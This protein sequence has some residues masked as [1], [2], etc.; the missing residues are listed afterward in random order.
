[1][2]FDPVIRKRILIGI[3]V[4]AGMLL[5]V[6][7]FILNSY[8]SL[9]KIGSEA[10]N[11]D[12]S[13]VT[14]DGTDK[15]AFNL[16]GIFMVPRSSSTIV[17]SGD[18]T[19][20]RAYVP[21]KAIIGITNVRVEISPQK[22]VSKIG[23]EGL[24]CNGVTATNA[25]FTYDCFG[26]SDTVFR[27]ANKKT[28]Q[29][30]NQPIAS[31]LNT[32]RSATKSYNDGILSLV[33]LSSS[34]VLEY[35]DI[36]KNESSQFSLPYGPSDFVDIATGAGDSF[37]VMNNTK[38]EMLFYPSLDS[39]RKKIALDKDRIYTTC[40]VHDEIITCGTVEATEEEKEDTDS[41]SAEDEESIKT[42][43]VV[44]FN[45]SD[46]KKRIYDLDD[47]VERICPTKS[48]VYILENRDVLRFAP[49][50]KDPFAIAG[51]VS[52][53]SCGLDSASYT[54]GSSVYTSD[55]VASRLTFTGSRFTI[56]SVQE[57]SGKVI[58][59]VFIRSD[60]LQT[61]HTYVVS[62]EALIGSRTENT[63]PYTT[64][65]LPVFTMDYDDDTIYIQPEV[66]VT[67]DKA[68]GIT[69]IDQELLTQTKRTIE[70]KLRQDGL[71]DAFTLRYY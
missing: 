60:P 17:V 8:V 30:E 63:L 16:L 66:S 2:I 57:L 35:T 46:D 58:F 27:Y 1:M 48:G 61:I 9:E 56:S 39:D 18:T 22:K 41:H 23:M 38:H 65:D 21:S 31:A 43:Q 15:P 68:L 69:T 28:G 42:A 71:L 40:G 54:K 29:F 4:I 3:S 51:G 67:S 49:E 33:P 55:V 36:E 10:N 6:Y 11:V 20:T 7:F 25:M 13:Y 34:M 70:D 32:S 19:E 44:W 59:S 24:S 26:A 5:I 50:G 37:I 14:V 52:S 62:E 45:A 64:T 53:L 47:T 12:V